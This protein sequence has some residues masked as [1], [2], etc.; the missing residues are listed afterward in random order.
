MKIYPLSIFLTT[1]ILKFMGI[2]LLSKKKKHWELPWTI[3]EIFKVKKY[4][5][6][7]FISQRELFNVFRN[8]KDH[9]KKSEKV[10]FKDSIIKS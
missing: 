1:E 2:C 5:L 9:L 6:L 7:I 4:S 3:R 10:W 8:S